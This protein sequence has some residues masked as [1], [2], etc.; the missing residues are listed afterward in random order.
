MCIWGARACF[1]GG[2]F[3]SPGDVVVR[4]FLIET[5]FSLLQQ[6]LHK[7][8]KCSRPPDGSEAVMKQP[9]ARE[10]S[11]LGGVI[12][13]SAASHPH[14]PHQTENAPQI[15]V[16][17]KWRAPQ[18]PPPCH[19]CCCRNVRDIYWSTKSGESS[20]CLRV[21]VK[22]GGSGAAPVCL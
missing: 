11:N 5:T 18:A 12:G 10:W 13:C 20:E 9:R 17:V 8:L 14:F 2:C 3:W 21:L 7:F 16:T 19:L 22:V 6:V 4:G 1:F 15:I